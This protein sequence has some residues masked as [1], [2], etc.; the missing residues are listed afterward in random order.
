M[1]KLFDLYLMSTCEW[2][3][4]VVIGCHLQAREYVSNY[5]DEMWSALTIAEPQDLTK[6]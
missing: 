3:I 4:R 5:S 1:S 6:Q 2:V